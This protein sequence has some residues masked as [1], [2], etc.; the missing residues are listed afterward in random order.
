MREKAWVLMQRFFLP[1]PAGALAATEG[2]SKANRLGSLDQGHA[3]LAADRALGCTRFS[4]PGAHR[5][6][7]LI[8]A[9]RIA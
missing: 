8:L 9:I 4:D 1:A 6:R 7:K 5:E 2:V 3:D